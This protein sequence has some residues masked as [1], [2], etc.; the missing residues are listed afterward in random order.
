M[1]PGDVLCCLRTRLTSKWQGSATRAI[2]VSRR[3]R[4]NCPKAAARFADR[5]KFSANPVTGTARL[6]PSR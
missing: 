3:H 2:V 1:L 4:S 6:C 5:E